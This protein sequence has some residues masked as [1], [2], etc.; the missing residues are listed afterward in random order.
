MI[1]RNV[2]SMVE[3]LG[4][5]KISR[6][7]IP[8][9][10]SI[11]KLQNSS[12]QKVSHQ[13]ANS[14]EN[15]GQ[16][17]TDKTKIQKLKDLF[18]LQTPEA[19]EIFGKYK[20]FAKTS[21][22]CINE[23]YSSCIGLGISKN[24]LL[25]Y[26]G[27]LAEENISL[28]VMTLKSL[29]LSINITAPLLLLNYNVLCNFVFKEVVEGR[30]K[31]ISRLFQVE[32]SEVCELMAEKP[33]ILS[34]DI[35]HLTTNLAL[36]SEFGIT[37]EDVIKDLWVLKYSPSAIK[38]RLNLAKS[39]N[40]ETMKTWMVRAQRD[41]FDTYIQRKSE[42]KTILGENS[43]VEYLSERLECS[44]PVAKSVILKQ[45]ALQNK[46]LKKM[47]EII[48]FLLN[49]GFKPVHICRT[50]KILLHRVETIE[51]RLKEMED[52]GIQTDALY[53]LT[54]SQKQYMQIIESYLANKNKN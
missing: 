39:Y 15:E 18:N 36:L 47:N 19:N 41:I 44:V 32:K 37:V 9:K 53:V 1:L 24:T 54:K 42:K 31:I 52:L 40:V 3:S 5:L 21:T 16:S 10:Y 6:R 28:K 51:K 8:G 20:K 49:N 38:E 23:N 34:I 12:Y 43:L 45:P 35:N 48:D 13:K 17:E 30:I 27:I 25:K 7:Q 22:N 46:S 2:F 11:V 50:P 4:L 14:V 26:P 33:F 29:P